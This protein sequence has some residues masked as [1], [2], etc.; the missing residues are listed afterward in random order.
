MVKELKSFDERQVTAESENR[1]AFGFKTGRHP[2]GFLRDSGAYSTGGAN[3]L[4]PPAVG[5]YDIPDKAYEN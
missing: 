3:P 5:H 4:E 2:N 1:V